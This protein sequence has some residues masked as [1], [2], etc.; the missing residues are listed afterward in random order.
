MVLKQSEQ[1]ELNEQR[2][3]LQ[4][5]DLISNFQLIT[6]PKEF[7]TRIVVH[8]TNAS[9]KHAY[10]NRIFKGEP[11]KNLN[12]DSN[13]HASFLNSE[14]FQTIAFASHSNTHTHTT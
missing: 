5:Y 2:Q 6:S 9:S 8:F 10:E 3:F 4:G 7:L 12:L 13:V 14:N 1:I 11:R